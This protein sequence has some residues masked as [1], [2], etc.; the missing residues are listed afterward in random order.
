[1][2]IKYNYLFE[3]IVNQA[4]DQLSGDHFYRNDYPYDSWVLTKQ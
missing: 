4:M 2:T 1:M 3:G